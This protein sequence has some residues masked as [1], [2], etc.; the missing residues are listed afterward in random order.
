[1]ADSADRPNVLLIMSDEHD[2]G[3]MGCYGD[4]IVDTGN[5][6][7]LADRGV[8]FENC[9]TNSPLCTP[10]R[11]SF[12]AGQYASRCGAWSND[13]W[14]P[15]DDYPTLPHAMA[16]AGYDCLLAGEHDFD[17]TRRYGFTDL[18][19]PPKNGHRTGTI[20]N[21]REPDDDS[22]NSGSWKSRTSDCYVGEDARHFDWDTEVTERCRAFLRDRDPG[23][24]PFFL[25]AGYI[26]PHF[27]LVA[28]IEYYRRY[29]GEVPLP[30]IPDGLLDSLP[31][32]YDQIR[33]GFGVTDVDHAGDKVRFARELYWALVDWFDDQVGAL[34][35]ALDDSAVA[36]DTVV[37][38]ASDHGEPKGDHGMWW[39]NCM[40]DHA[41]GVP[42]I[43]SW[44]ERWA[45]GQRR[46]DVCSLVDLTA[47][48]ADLGG[49]DAPG[50][51][52]G[53]SLVGLL[54]DPGA[55]WK[56]H[57]VSEYYA[58][59]TA[60]GFTM[61]REGRYK[62]VYH[63]RYDDEHGPEVELYD[64]QEDPDEFENLADRDAYS[65]IRE[66]LHQGLLAE[67]G[68]HPDEIERRALRQAAE[69]YDRSD[70]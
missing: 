18:Y 16:D 40:Y 63:A 61:Y 17:A 10:A 67:L 25:Q 21:R 59:G 35:D 30:E 9:Y 44:P 45:G 27:P 8:T 29:A 22:V 64:M 15:A 51:W 37:I 36:E 43:V 56:D 32:N 70:A 13:C 5:L 3:V 52:D 54:D 1:M 55:E 4:Q 11:L 7:G 48:I 12:T 68:E 39:K 49:A 33:R 69:G 41:A 38:Y 6:D 24:D 47:T 2:R 46:T 31:T 53:D 62:Y 20:P 66:H 60:T 57:A 26:A 19:P 42:L 23:D 14:L 58:G 65:E 34:L 50:Q 28:P